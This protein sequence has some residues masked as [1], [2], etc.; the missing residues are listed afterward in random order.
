MFDEQLA[1]PVSKH[2]CEKEYP[3]L[4]SWSSISGHRRTMPRPQ[5]HRK[6][7]PRAQNRALTACQ[8][9][10]LAGRFC[11]PYGCSSGIA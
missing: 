7:R 1:R 5:K 8:L 4:T 3:T 9:V 6:G 10:G 11:A 2:N